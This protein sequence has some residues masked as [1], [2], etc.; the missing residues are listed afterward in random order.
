MLYV[1]VLLSHFPWLFLVSVNECISKV[2]HC[3]PHHFL[4]PLFM[5]SQSPE[6]KA[7]TCNDKAYQKWPY[8]AQ[9]KVSKKWTW[10]IRHLGDTRVRIAQFTERQKHLAVLM[11]C[12]VVIQ[13]ELQAPELLTLNDNKWHLDDLNFVL[14]GVLIEIIDFVISYC[15]IFLY[16]LFSLIVF[17]ERH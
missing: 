10:I 1:Y 11:K 6:N 5:E 7:L 4:W 15:T 9:V 8:S 2:S 14:C 3:Q 17:N 13:F 12:N 16:F